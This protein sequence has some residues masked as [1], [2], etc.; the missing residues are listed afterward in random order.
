VEK[1]ITVFLDVMSLMN[2]DTRR[3]VNI[4]NPASRANMNHILFFLS[5][6]K[7]FH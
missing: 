2:D 1:V 5:G 6:V 7:G 3:F 4:I